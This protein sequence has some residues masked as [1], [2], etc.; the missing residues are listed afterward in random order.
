[1][2]YMPLTNFDRWKL[3][4]SNLPSPDSFI[5]FSFYSMIATA[6][7]RKVWMGTEL[8][9]DSHALF[10]NI[11][12]FLV[13]PPAAGKGL[14][15]KPTSAMLKHYRI[16]I[17][18][19]EVKVID[20]EDNAMMALGEDG[21]A[22]E[23]YLFPPLPDST[24]FEKLVQKMAISTRK[25]PYL[26]TDGSKGCYTHNSA[27]FNLEELSSLLKKHTEG[28]SQ[29][30]LNAYD[31]SD[32]TRE[33]KHGA[34][35]MIRKPCLNI[36]AG[37]TPSYLDEIFTG[38]VLDDGLSSRCWFV[39]EFA[40]RFHAWR[41]AEQT[42]EQKQA[43]REILVHIKQLANIFGRL[44]FTSEADEYLCEWWETQHP[45]KKP[46]NSMRLAS[47]YGRKNIHVKKL[48][49]IM[50]LAESLELG[51]VI[52]LETAIRAKEE[53]DSVERKMHHA[54][55]FGRR[56]PLA[57]AGDT[58][59]EFMIKIKR[60]VT[61]QELH[62]ETWRDLRLPEL[63]EVINHLTEVKK[64]YMHGNTYVITK[65]AENGQYK[66]IP[67]KNKLGAPNPKDIKA[68]PLDEKSCPVCNGTK[69]FNGLCVVCVESKPEVKEGVIG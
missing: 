44:E 11:Y 43:K 10:P 63:V 38:R 41:I 45:T 54:L 60:P 7:G 35:D 56:N 57:A 40:P 3:A 69:F 8:P 6:I 53:L 61:Q 29:F 66:E 42:E 17:E 4:T 55:N 34:P 27:Y 12:V 62:E 68:L 26:K 14:I 36:L 49:M 65:L 9:T 67:R 39:F 28:I 13:G 33:I 50:H 51:Q 32:Y 48:A 1:M 37:T 20:T 16:R 2:S 31:C 19:T 15:I 22:K 64:I 24:T 21:N 58:I 25:V 5:N 18:G 47:Y 59:V 30:M 46:N 52:P 23:L